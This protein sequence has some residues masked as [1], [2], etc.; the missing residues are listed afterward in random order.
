MFLAG[1]RGVHRDRPVAGHVEGALRRLSRAGLQI[2]LDDFGTGYASLAHLMQFPVDALKID[3]SFIKGIG[4]NEGA[5]A[6]TKAI[7]TLGQSLGIEIIAEGVESADQEMY[8]IGVGCQTRQGY[9]Y[10]KAIGAETVRQMTAES[11]ARRA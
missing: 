7:V 4:S 8:L 9:L 2:A 3:K 5:E 6:I 11:L 10:S 1:H